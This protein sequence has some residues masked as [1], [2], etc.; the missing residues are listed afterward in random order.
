MATDNELSLIM[1]KIM[2]KQK[3]IDIISY[4]YNSFFSTMDIFFQ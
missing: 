2:D 1:D 3:S 4:I